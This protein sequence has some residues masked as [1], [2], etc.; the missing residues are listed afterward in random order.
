MCAL[1]NVYQRHAQT[2]TD[3]F[4]YGENWKFIQF[5]SLRKEDWR[6]AFSRT[7]NAQTNS[8]YVRAPRY[9]KINEVIKRQHIININ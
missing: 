6:F 8:T 7:A 1:W 9:P 4:G 3:L 2:H 5:L